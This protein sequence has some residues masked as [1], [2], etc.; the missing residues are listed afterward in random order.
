MQRDPAPG[1]PIVDHAQ[2][3]IVSAATGYHRASCKIPA[4]LSSLR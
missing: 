1:S 3:Q 2:L 4:W